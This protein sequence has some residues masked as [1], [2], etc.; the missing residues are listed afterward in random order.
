MVSGNICT[1]VDDLIFTGTD[2]FLS[3]FARE[4]KKSLQIGSLNENDV[5]FRGQ[6]ILKQCASV[7][8]HQDLCIEDFHEAP[9]PKGKDMD[10]PVGPD[11]TEYRS[12]LGKLSWLQPRTQFH[13]SD[14]SSRCASAS[15][16]ATI[17]DA[18]EL[19]KVV[20]LVKD[21]AQRLL[22]APINGVRPVHGF[23]S[24]SKILGFIAFPPAP[25]TSFWGNRACLGEMLL[26]T[27]F[28]P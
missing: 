6:R 24:G 9:F 26:L 18:K 8:I 3:S 4:L 7:T 11:L 20:C 27:V 15:A 13:I 17:L 10:P 19:N 28:M 12:I 1:H 25:V 22:Y 2:D 23:F 14:H 16:S 21:K 5:M